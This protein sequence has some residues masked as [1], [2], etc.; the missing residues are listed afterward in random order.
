VLTPSDEPG[1]FAPSDE[2][3]IF[4]PSDELGIFASSDDF[5]AS[6]NEPGE[7]AFIK[8]DALMGNGSE[9]DDFMAKM[10]VL[11]AERKI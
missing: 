8:R 9:Q 2:P 6:Y 10:T 5:G 4:A 11:R 3:G 7:R 1:I